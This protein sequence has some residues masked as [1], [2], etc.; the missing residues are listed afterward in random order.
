M[1]LHAHDRPKIPTNTARVA[2]AAS[3]EGNVYL[4]MRGDIVKSATGQMSLLGAE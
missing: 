3:L 4:T 2:R 1:A